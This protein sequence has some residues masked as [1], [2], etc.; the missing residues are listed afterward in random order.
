MIGHGEIADAN[1]DLVMLSY[2]QGVYTGKY[3]AV[4]APEVEIQHR[5]HLGRVASRI[6][7]VG[8]QKKDEITIHFLDQGMLL[9][10]V[11]HPESHHSH[12]HLD[13]FIRVGV[14]HE[15]SRAARHE[16]IDESLTGRDAGLGQSCH[17]VHAIGNALS[18]PVNAVYFRKLVGDKNPHSITFHHFDRRSWT[19]A[20]VSPKVSL[21]TRGHFPDN[22][23][24]D[25][26]KLLDTLIHPPGQGPAVQSDDGVVRH[27]RVGCQRGH[28][29]RPGLNHRFG[30]TS[31]RDRAD[32]RRRDR[33][34]DGAGPMN[35][36]A[37]RNHVFRFSELRRRIRGLGANPLG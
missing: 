27:A 16:F 9:P 5:H 20:V 24:C 32:R 2:H 31:Q 14:I 26:M 3:P 18:V 34:R 15:G 23:F 22:G 1:A 10:G 21:E 29:V 17:T 19:L 12:R 36:I 4:P 28:G 37:S 8:T 33:S 13:H 6:D 7:I 11:G 35:E 30:Q 25:E